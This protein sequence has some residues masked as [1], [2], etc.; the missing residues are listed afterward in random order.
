MLDK[1]WFALSVLLVTAGAVGFGLSVID[2]V[3][4]L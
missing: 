3:R 1:L 2:F 4:H